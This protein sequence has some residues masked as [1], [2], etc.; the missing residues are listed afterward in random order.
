MRFNENI[1]ECFPDPTSY[2]QTNIITVAY[3]WKSH[4]TQTHLKEKYKRKSEVKRE[5]HIKEIKGKCSQ[6]HLQLNQMLQNKP[7]PK[8]IYKKPHT[9]GLFTSV[10]TTQ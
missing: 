9:K 6:R 3:K 2:H 1:M 8:Q 10:S 7:T 5:T 4:K